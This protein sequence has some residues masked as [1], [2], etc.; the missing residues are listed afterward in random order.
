[1]GQIQLVDEE[2]AKN[3]EREHQLGRKLSQTFGKRQYKPNEL[4]H[5]STGTGFVSVVIRL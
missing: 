5:P 1:M 4:L 2:E 3:R